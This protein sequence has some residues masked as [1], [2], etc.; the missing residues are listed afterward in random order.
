MDE[1]RVGLSPILQRAWVHKGTRPRVIV[2]QRFECLYLYGFVCPISGQVE[3]L[4]LP[5]VD[6]EIFTLALQHFARA[7]GAGPDKHIVLVLDQAGWHIGQ[8]VR[9]Q[10]AHPFRFSSSLFS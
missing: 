5:T 3:W 1:H 2:H 9:I 10:K 6:E 8:D 7:V 4:L